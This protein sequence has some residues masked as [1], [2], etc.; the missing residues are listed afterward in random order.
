LIEKRHVRRRRDRCGSD[1][2]LARMKFRKSVSADFDARTRRNSSGLQLNNVGHF[3]Q[4]FWRELRRDRIQQSLPR[5]IWMDGIGDDGLSRMKSVGAFARQRFAGIG[6]RSQ[7][8]LCGGDLK[9]G[10]IFDGA[11]PGE[12]RV[13]EGGIV[14][15]DGGQQ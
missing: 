3:G 14:A 2:M 6:V 8:G 7:L 12:L 1:T 11:G 13:V 5:M 10:E 15:N 4:E 9:R